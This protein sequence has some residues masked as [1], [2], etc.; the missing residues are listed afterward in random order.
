MFQTC[1]ILFTDFWQYQ[2]QRDAC[3]VGQWLSAIQLV[4][5]LREL[6]CMQST[7]ASTLRAASRALSCYLSSVLGGPLKTPIISCIYNYF[8]SNSQV[9]ISFRKSNHSVSNE[10]FWSQIPWFESPFIFQLRLVFAH[11]WFSLLLYAPCAE[12]HR[13]VRHCAETESKPLLQ[14]PASGTQGVN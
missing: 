4:A 14:A 9:F 2:K 13:A 5:S 3:A 7:S 11:H 12:T 10:I 6:S 1:H 8:K